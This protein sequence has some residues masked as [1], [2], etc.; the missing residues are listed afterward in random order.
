MSTNDKFPRFLKWI[1]FKQADNR[2][3][4]LACILFFISE[5]V[6]V[7]N[8]PDRPRAGS[9]SVGHHNHCQCIHCN[10]AA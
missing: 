4:S 3:R 5:L 2:L 10:N 8:L 1:S 7:T 6:K 9:K